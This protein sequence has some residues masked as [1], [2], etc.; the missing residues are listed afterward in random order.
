MKIVTVF[1]TAA[2]LTL[3]VAANAHL[4]GGDY[5]KKYSDPHTHYIGHDYHYHH[6]AGTHYEHPHKDDRR[7]YHPGRRDRG[8][9]SFKAEKFDC[10]HGYTWSYEYKGCVN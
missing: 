6:G 4:F 1:V 9:K 8:Y 7:H 3:P 2:A 5:H 10:P